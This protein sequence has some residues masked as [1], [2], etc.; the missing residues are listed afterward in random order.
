[1]RRGV[2]L[3]RFSGDTAPQED[4]NTDNHRNH[5]SMYNLFLHAAFNIDRSALKVIYILIMLKTTVSGSAKPPMATDYAVFYEFP[6][7]ILVP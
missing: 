5:H 2:F 6:E 4:T 7:P 3:A 1:M